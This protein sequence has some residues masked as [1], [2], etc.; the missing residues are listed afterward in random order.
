MSQK[1]L[2]KI[3]EVWKRLIVTFFASSCACA[4]A[5]WSPFSCLPRSCYPCV[6]HLLLQLAVNFVLVLVLYIMFT[7]IACAHAK[8]RSSSEASP[9]RLRLFY[10]QCR[11]YT[12]FTTKKWI[13]DGVCENG[14]KTNNTGIV[15]GEIGVKVKRRESLPR[16]YAMH[17]E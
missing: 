2:E 7:P 13:G 9:P 10:R 15:I 4:T 11:E 17:D 16:E 1:K 3:S 6:G 5:S 12:I 14:E 8:R